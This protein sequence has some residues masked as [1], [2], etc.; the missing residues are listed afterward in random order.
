MKYRIERYYEEHL[1]KMR[2]D[3]ISCGFLLDNGQDNGIH[4]NRL[5]TFQELEDLNVR[6]IYTRQIFETPEEERKFRKELRSEMFKKVLAPAVGIATLVGSLLF[7]GILIGHKL[8]ERTVTPSPEQVKKLE[9]VGNYGNG[10]YNP[11]ETYLYNTGKLL[12]V[13]DLYH[14]EF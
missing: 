2:N 7:G 14:K 6:M 4:S 12:S 5:Y 1:E 9:S 11:P 8:E 3:A 10:H 13:K